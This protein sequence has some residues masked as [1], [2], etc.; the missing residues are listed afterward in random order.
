MSIT[1]DQV[2]TLATRDNETKR[3]LRLWAEKQGHDRCWYYPDLFRQ[4]MELHGIE[5]PADLGQPS[6]D[7]FQAGCKRFQTEEYGL[8]QAPDI[9]PIQNLP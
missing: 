3:I 8:M 7:E 5:L 9:N 2:L 6:L 1:G 4:L